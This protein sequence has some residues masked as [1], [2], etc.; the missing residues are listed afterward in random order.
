VIEQPTPSQKLSEEDEKV[1][2]V[3]TSLSLEV[4]KIN[5]VKKRMS[6]VAKKM[7][8][9][10]QQYSIIRRWRE[11]SINRIYARVDPAGPARLLFAR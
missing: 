7:Y 11:A 8:A 3:L 2:K 1:A 9:L 4:L 6:G 10:A 5:S